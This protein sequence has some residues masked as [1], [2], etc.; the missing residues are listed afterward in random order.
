MV[1]VAEAA[2]VYQEAEQLVT[3][4]EMQQA[5]VRIAGEISAR[6]QKSNPLLITLMTGG[7]VACGQLLPLL[8]FPLQCDYLHASRYGD[9]T[10]GN[11]LNWHAVPQT[12][13]SGRTVLIIDD[14]LDEGI[15]L[16]EVIAWCQQQGA[17]EVFSAV[18]VKKLHQRNVGIEADFV[19]VELPDRYLF[20]YG[21]DYHHYWRNAPGIFA[22]RGL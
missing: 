2:L 8:N 22:V 12:P 17:A 21:M 7:V 16:K 10:V 20:G 9:A 14:I 5:I 13:L 1:T 4:A 6:L 11:H 3:A 19:G 15:T 18:L